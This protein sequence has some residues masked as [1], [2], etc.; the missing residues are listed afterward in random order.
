MNGM[1]MKL[2]LLFVQ[3]NLQFGS[4]DYKYLKCKVMKSKILII[5]FFY[6]CSVCYAQYDIYQSFTENKTNNF[7]HTLYIENLL[8]IFYDCSYALA[9]KHKITAAAG[10]GC[11][12]FEISFCLSMLLNYMYGTNNSHLEIGTG[13]QFPEFYMQYSS[14]NGNKCIYDVWKFSSYYDIPLS[15]GYRYQKID[16]GLFWKVAFVAL[17]SEEIIKKMPFA[18]SSKVAIG[19]TF[20]NKSH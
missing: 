3:S 6:I 8:S 12:L 2:K 20:K 18:P 19:Y 13:I 16:G 7:Q 14:C 4:T 15:I 5:L 10:F 1:K 9:D 11:N 17:F